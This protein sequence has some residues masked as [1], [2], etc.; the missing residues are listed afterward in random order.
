MELKEHLQ[1]KGA[2]SFLKQELVK[3]LGSNIDISCIQRGL[4]II[5]QFSKNNVALAQQHCV[6]L[7][8]LNYHLR[9]I[10]RKNPESFKLFRKRLFRERKLSDFFSLRYEIFI[11]HNLCC[12]NL[13]Y[14]QPDLPDFEVYLNDEI[15]FLEC[16]SCQLTSQSFDKNDLKYELE[17]VINKKSN[18]NYAHNLALYVEISNIS[19]SFAQDM[20]ISSD[21]IDNFIKG[22]DNFNKFG[23]VI[24]HTI[25]RDDKDAQVKYL[26]SRTD[27]Q[28]ISKSLI[29]VLNKINPKDNRVIFEKGSL[30][31]VTIPVTKGATRYK[32]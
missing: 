3:T 14:R 2:A 24:T 31:Q 22:I 12:Y 11:A 6:L 21:Y 9:L 20:S 8:Y 15:A 30:F 25:I 4:E 17:S 19:I 16:G 5:D 27:H 28:N 26:Y 29:E 1:V 10:K 18:N 23:S 13:Q 32:K 7:K